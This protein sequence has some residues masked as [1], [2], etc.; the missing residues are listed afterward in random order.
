ML[1][2]ERE[3]GEA[4]EK[5]RNKRLSKYALLFVYLSLSSFVFCYT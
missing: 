4:E 2:G 1:S 5:R 3:G